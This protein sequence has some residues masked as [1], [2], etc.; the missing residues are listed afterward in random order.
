MNGWCNC[1]I[2]IASDHRT[3]LLQQLLETK[4]G[5][6][7]PQSCKSYCSTPKYVGLYSARLLNSSISKIIVLILSFEHRDIRKNSIASNVFT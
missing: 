7:V 3:T 1:R 4:K 6:H 5:A 2:A